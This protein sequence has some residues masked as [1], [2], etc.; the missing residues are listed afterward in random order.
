MSIMKDHIKNALGLAAVAAL[1]A[2]SLSSFLYVKSYSKTQTFSFSVSAQGEAVAIPDVAQFQVSVIT[3]GGTNV[4]DLQEQ[5]AEKSNRISD[6]LKEQGVDEKDIKTQQ[7]SIEPRY[8][9]VPCRYEGDI[10]PPPTI[11]GYQVSQSL[12]VKVRN[13]ETIGAILSGVVDRGANAISG[14]S[15]TVD[16]P[17]VAEQKAREEAIVKAKEKAKATAKAGGFRLGRILS[18]NEGGFGISYFEKASP[19]LEP[20][21]QKVQVQ[22]TLVYEIE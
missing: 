17:A 13:F 19:Y 22:V 4:A 11:V 1:L 2:F 5:N 7:Y 18:M 9:Y 14:P 6:F 15:F 21:S 3:Q 16:D 8:Q 20:G 10:C 12:E